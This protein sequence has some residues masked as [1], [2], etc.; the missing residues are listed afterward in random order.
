[1]FN[2]FAE[3]LF[4][5][6]KGKGAHYYRTNKG[7]DALIEKG[8]E[9]YTGGLLKASTRPLEK[10]IIEFGATVSNKSYADKTFERAKLIFKNCLDLRRT[11][12]TALAICY[13][14][15][16]RLDGYFEQVIKPWDYAAAILILAEAGGK[17]SD[18]QGNELP[19][20][21]SGTIICANATIHQNLKKLVNE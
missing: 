17:S 13:I 5:A 21:K 19:L 7:I 18:W 2:P 3:E 11:C 15:A 1:M 9:N 4:F 8:V 20:D 6:I 14:A 12:S 16:G 10:S